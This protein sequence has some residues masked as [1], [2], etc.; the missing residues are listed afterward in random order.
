MKK[1]S[2]PKWEDLLK[3]GVY[4][5]GTALESVIGKAGKFK[6]NLKSSS[7]QM[8]AQP[9]LSL[10]GQIPIP[11]IKEILSH[12]SEKIIAPTIPTL[13]DK[14]A[15]EIREGPQALATLYKEKGSS[16]AIHIDVGGSGGS[17]TKAETGISSLRGS[18]SRLP[19]EDGFFDF[20]SGIYCNQFQGDIFKAIKEFSR[21]LAISGEG[22]IVDFHP[23]GLYA[24]RGS[25][26]LKPVEATV[27]GLEEYYKMC[28]S[29][30]LKI[31]GVRESFLDETLRSLFVTESE[32]MAFRMVKDTPLL[33]YL[34]VRKG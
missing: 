3:K 12:V 11:K 28:K 27:K 16:A 30:S 10:E 24:K 15:L 2:S 33:I 13:V 7:S 21:I 31:T 29:A 25:L 32:K 6:A 17:Y 20:I 8:S 14:T 26:R 4:T 9:V 18:T 5:V 1:K 34:M 22:V 23:F 19:F